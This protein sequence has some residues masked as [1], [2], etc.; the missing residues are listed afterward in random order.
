MTAKWV[1]GERHFP[2]SVLTAKFVGCD[3]SLM[4]RGWAERRWHTRTMEWMSRI[5]VH[6]KVNGPRGPL[7]A[8]WVGRNV[9]RTQMGGPRDG[10]RDDWAARRVYREVGG[11][12]C[13]R[14]RV[15]TGPRDFLAARCVGREV[16]GRNVS[17][18]RGGRQR[19]GWA[20]RWVGGTRWAY[21]ECVGRH[22]D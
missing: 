15:V 6:R 1:V 21:A 3:V 8:K 10:P 14:G 19:D 13:G 12:Q 20:K 18:Q 11:P 4:R 5:W 22:H 17:W 7:A 16:G 2:Q 9:R